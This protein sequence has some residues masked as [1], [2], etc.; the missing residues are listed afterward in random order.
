MKRVT[1]QN[2]LTRHISFV[3]TEEIDTDNNRK[4]FCDDV[5]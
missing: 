2:I 3:Y 1:Y 4:K 5:S